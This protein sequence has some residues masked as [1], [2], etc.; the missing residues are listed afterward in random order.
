MRLPL[1]PEQ[2]HFV[3]PRYWARWTVPPRGHHH[4]IDTGTTPVGPA[5]GV[6]DPEEHQPSLQPIAVT[7]L[8]SPPPSPA[9]SPST[10]TTDDVWGLVT[11]KVTS[12]RQ[13]Y[14]LGVRT[15][16]IKG[17]SK[18]FLWGW[19]MVHGH[20]RCL[21]EIGCYGKEKKKRIWQLANR[22]HNKQELFPSTSECLLMSCINRWVAKMTAFYKIRYRHILRL[23][24]H[25]WHTSQHSDGSSMD[26]HS[27][28]SWD[29]ML[30]VC[31]CNNIKT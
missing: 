9:S 20:N 27:Q 15:L 18:S 24:E 29:P 19:S 28:Q 26:R 12:Q 2:F 21:L 10:T 17:F 22:V 16:I 1:I 14:S 11:V 31:T 23:P 25:T 7:V 30:P 13:Q 8:G 3:S 6:R 4:T 5:R